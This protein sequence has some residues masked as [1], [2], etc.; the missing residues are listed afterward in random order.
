MVLPRAMIPLIPLPLPNDRDF[1]FHPATQA[2][3]TLFMHFVDHQTSKVLIKNISSQMFCI[4]RCHKLGHLIDIA[5]ENCFFANTHAALDAA[6]SPPLL[7]HLSDHDTSSPLLPTD[8]SLETVLSN[9]VRVYGDTTTVRQIAELVAKYPTIWEFQG[10]VQISPERW[11]TVPLKLGWKSKVSAIKPRIYSLGN[12]ARHVVDNTFDEIYKPGR[13]QYT[14][15][16][17]LF[18]FLVFVIYKTD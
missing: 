16:Q 2:N 9:G 5:Y 15:N 10:F 17:T 8:S 11:M 1:L 7:Q 12:E 6:T 18:S 14:T 4:L 13:L 3:L